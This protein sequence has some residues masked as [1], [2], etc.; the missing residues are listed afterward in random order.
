MA[1]RDFYP[2]KKDESSTK[3]NL[4]I[5]P[6]R[7]NFPK[8]L[9]LTPSETTP[10]EKFMD[11]RFY[12]IAITK[13][14]NVGPITAKHLISYCGSAGAVFKSSK[15]FL[16]KIPH[17]GIEI[18]QAI[19]SSNALRLAEKEMEYLEKHQIKVLFAG[20]REYPER[21]K[22]INDAPILLYYKGNSNLN[23]P[24]VI[25]IVGTRRATE[26]GIVKCEQFI[27]SIAQ[28]NPLIIS[29]LAYGIDIAAHRFCNKIRLPNIGIVGHGLDRIYPPQHRHT[30]KEMIENG[31]LLSEY[32]IGT[33]PDAR[34]FP[35]RNRIIAG[36]SDAVIVIETGTKGG[37]MITA[38]LANSY[39]K[40]V[41]AFPGRSNDPLSKGC[42]LLIKSHRAQLIE[43]GEDLINA[44]NWDI[45]DE[46]NIIQP[47]LFVEL[48]E[49]EKKVLALIPAEKPIFIDFLTH[50]MKISPSKVAA[51]L[52]D[53]ECK[54]LIKSLPGKRFMLC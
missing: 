29:G 39:H 18:I 17:V 3:Y 23:A 43:S 1:F 34:H 47:K 19:Q 33:L 32:A 24:R 38:D 40:D 13:I 37:S 5:R 25:S 21:L 22:P 20:D 35:M 50:Q 41:F 48:S 15:R 54:G 42:N 12:E 28:F 46:P 9:G 49:Q 6:N 31:G 16:Q 26:R 36:I 53:L 45:Q 8:T 27:Q 7:E 4:K 52:L 30:A 51:I 10:S 2:N 14:P 44:L 11:N